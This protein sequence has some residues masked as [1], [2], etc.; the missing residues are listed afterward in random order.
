MLRA[1]MTFAFLFN[2]IM[3]FIKKAIIQ[4]LEFIADEALKE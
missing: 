3:W 1:I 4:N 2:P